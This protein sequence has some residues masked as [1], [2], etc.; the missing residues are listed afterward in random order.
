MKS[1]DYADEP[2]INEESGE[3]MEADSDSDSNSLRSPPAKKQMPSNSVTEQYKK[4]TPEISLQSRDR[5]HMEAD[6]DSDTIS[7]RS[8]PVKKRMPSNA[9]DEYK[10][11]KN[12]NSLATRS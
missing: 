3:Y 6:G 9:T 8:P 5:E 12:K 1:Q 10:K 2:Q 7:L 4:K 11:N